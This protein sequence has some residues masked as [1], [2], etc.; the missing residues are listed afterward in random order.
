[1]TLAMW[2]KI[3]GTIG[4][5]VFAASAFVVTYGAKQILL[6]VG[7]GLMAVSSIIASSTSAGHP[8]GALTTKEQ[9]APLVIGK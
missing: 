1:M 2:A 8:D 6:A 4:G 5:T 3:V 9:S 7:G